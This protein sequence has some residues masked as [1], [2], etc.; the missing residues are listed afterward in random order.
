MP[1]LAALIHNRHS[2]RVPFDPDRRVGERD[3]RS[4]LEAARWAPSAHNMQTFEI[5]VVDDKAAL[6]ALAAIPFRPSETFLRENHRQLSFSEDEP[7]CKGTGPLAEMFPLA[8]RI[9]D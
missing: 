3:L 5:I 7:R 9:R 4:I 2:A 8:W 1:D 6:A